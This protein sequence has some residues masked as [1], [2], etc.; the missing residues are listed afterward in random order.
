MMKGRLTMEK[1]RVFLFAVT[2]GLGG[3]SGGGGTD[4][5]TDAGGD[6]GDGVESDAG[7]GG[8]KVDCRFDPAVEWFLLGEILQMESEDKGTCVWLSR[9]NLC[10]QG[11]VCKEVPFDLLAVRI[12][13]GGK[14]VEMDKNNS[15]LTWQGTWHNWEDVGTATHQGTTYTLQGVAFGQQYDLTAAG[16]ESFGPIRLL[17]Y[18][19]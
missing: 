6:D 3:C 5:G 8:G 18:S 17:P 12:G 14:L 4:A 16:S 19:P 11:W 15:S 9:K 10:P 1:W 7:D 2:L 13:H